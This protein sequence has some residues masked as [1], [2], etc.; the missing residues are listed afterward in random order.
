MGRTLGCP[1]V[2]II[3]GTLADTIDLSFCAES[4]FHTTRFTRIVVVFVAW[5]V[6]ITDFS[7]LGVRV[8]S[9][10]SVFLTTLL[11]T[12]S[13]PL[14]AESKPVTSRYTCVA[15]A[16]KVDVFFFSLFH[17]IKVGLFINSRFLSSHAYIIYIIFFF[18]RAAISMTVANATLLP[19]MAESK[20][21][22]TTSFA[23][24]RI[25]IL[26]GRIAARG[27]LARMGSRGRSPVIAVFFV[28]VLNA[29]RL[30]TRAE[31]KPV[32]STHARMVV[33]GDFNVDIIGAS[34]FFLHALRHFGCTQTKAGFA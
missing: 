21:L 5:K 19:L 8:R 2:K 34:T 33:T 27:I 25:L 31:S 7:T 11:N 18:V 22:T 23:L 13:L 1:R 30:L 4:E 3:S 28:A 10:V 14:L 20:P 29:L 26:A 9:L 12:I 6:S 16:W 15:V 24:L 32:A 17:T